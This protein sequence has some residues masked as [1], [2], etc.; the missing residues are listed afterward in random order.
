MHSSNYAFDNRQSIQSIDAV[1]LHESRRSS[2]DS[3]VNLG[4]GHLQITPSSPYQEQNASRT[5]LVSSL[6]QQRGITSDANR[7]SGGPLSPLGS[8]MGPR[9][10]A[11]PR[12]APVI[13]PNPRSVTGMPNPTAAAPT[14][15]YAWAFPDENDENRESSDSASERMPSR[16]NSFAASVNSSIYTIDSQLPPGQRRL[17]DGTGKDT[18]LGRRVC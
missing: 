1:S 2:V 18:N 8:R 12:R 6:Q 10:Q 15:G 5:S 14:K 3:R 4:M 9:A 11:A 7:L 13:S 17:E 16:A